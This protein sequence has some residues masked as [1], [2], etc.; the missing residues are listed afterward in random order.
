MPP[1]NTRQKINETK[2]Y[3]HKIHKN[4]VK[5]AKLQVTRKT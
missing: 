5:K 3:K 2:K 1:G 4:K